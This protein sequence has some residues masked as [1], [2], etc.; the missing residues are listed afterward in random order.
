MGTI[1]HSVKLRKKNKISENSL[2]CRTTK[3]KRSVGQDEK[4]ASH[5]SGEF[6]LTILLLLSH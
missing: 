3:R 5:T 4:K 1:K 2:C 6:F